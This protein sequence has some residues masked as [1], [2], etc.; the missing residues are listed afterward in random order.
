MKIETLN[1]LVR[2]GFAVTIFGTVII[3]SMAQEF[4]RPKPSATNRPSMQ[5]PGGKAHGGNNNRGRLTGDYLWGVTNGNRTFDK[6]VYARVPQETID[7][8]L[9]LDG[10]TY[11]IARAASGARV[12]Q[13]ATGSIRDLLFPS[14]LLDDEATVGIAPING[15]T[16]IAPTGR[17]VIGASWLSAVSGPSTHFTGTV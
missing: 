9:F 8:P 3:P 2:T 15:A 7:S 1:A 12:G 16:A 6:P 17:V 10:W 13:N 11:P 4:T 5:N 14:V